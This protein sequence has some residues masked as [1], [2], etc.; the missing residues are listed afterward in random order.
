MCHFT[1]DIYTKI[2]LLLR[3]ANDLFTL[4]EAKGRF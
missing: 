2:N 4:L 1:N 3:S